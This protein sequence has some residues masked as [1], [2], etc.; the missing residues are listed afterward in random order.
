MNTRSLSNEHAHWAAHFAR[1][2]ERLL[3]ALGPLTEGGVVEGLQHIGATSVPNLPAQPCVDMALAV[4]P[5]PLEEQAR[6]ALRDLGYEPV[7]DYTAAPE[8]RFRHTADPVQLFIVEPGTDNWLDHLLLRDYLVNAAAPREAYAALKHA[9]PLDSSEYPAA[10]A[11]WF[12][13]ALEPARRW[14]I[15]HTGFTPVQRI[16]HELAD[17][18]G[19]WY[20]SSGWALDLFL[21][22][23]TRV[24]HDVD[25]VVDRSHQLPLRQHLLDRGWKLVTPFENRLQ[26]WP[27]HMTLELPRHQVHAHRDGD[28]IDILLTDLSHALWHYRRQPGVVR[29]LERA[30]C[31]ADGVRYLAPEL[32]LLFKS[33]NTSGKPRPHDRADFEIVCAHLEPER[34]AWLRWALTAT[35]PS[36]PWIARL[37]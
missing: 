10:K 37:T 34:R 6:A 36:H 33:Q 16:A 9:H 27:P 2:R 14:W 3:S 11:Q 24:H 31:Q 35:D 22:R 13:A 28:F 5:F 25:V 8:Q 26:P 17:F 7:T 1:E 20:I 4:W 18:T 30:V 29:T 32:S 12:T 23:V 19:T 21:G 15:E